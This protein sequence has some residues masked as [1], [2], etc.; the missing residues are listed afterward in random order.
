MPNRKPYGTARAALAVLLAAALAN[1]PQ[2]ADQDAVPP[3]FPKEQRDKL[4]RFLEQHQ[5]PDRFVPPDAKLVGARPPGQELPKEN[6]AG[7]SVKQYLVQ[8]I[9]H[10]PVPGQEEVKQVD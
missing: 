10:R 5:K 1:S 3:Q 7:K 6:A 2:A 4:Q 9:S 8:I